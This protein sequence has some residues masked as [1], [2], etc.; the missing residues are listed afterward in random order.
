MFNA[1][2]VDPVAVESV[3]TELVMATMP[4]INNISE[5]PRDLDTTNNVV[6]L[7]V[8]FLMQDLLS[9]DPIDLST[10]S[11]WKA[12]ISLA[13]IEAGRIQEEGWFLGK[14]SLPPT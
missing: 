12:K 14:N 7:A 9:D 8:E 1:T 5:F 10:V 2:N 3:L 6:S 11:L 13:D 4:S